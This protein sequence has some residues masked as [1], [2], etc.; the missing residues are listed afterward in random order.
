M[1]HYLFSRLLINAK[2]SVVLF[3]FEEV[4]WDH[5]QSTERLL[6]RKDKSKVDDVP[7][8]M[9]PSPQSEWQKRAKKNNWKLYWEETEDTMLSYV[10]SPQSTRFSKG[11]ANTMLIILTEHKLLLHSIVP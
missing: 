3:Q 9:K 5:A 8:Q 6:K 2:G 4:E 11:P 1:L 10:I 7:F